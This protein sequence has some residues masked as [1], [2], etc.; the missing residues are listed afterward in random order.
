MRAFFMAGDLATL[1][2]ENLLRWP[3]L[4]SSKPITIASALV[5]LRDRLIY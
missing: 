1:M 2:A 3:D 4:R 5:K